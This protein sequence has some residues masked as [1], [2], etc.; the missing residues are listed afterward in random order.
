[1]FDSFM[2]RHIERFRWR[3]KAPN[4][5]NIETDAGPMK[6]VHDDQLADGRP[7]PWIDKVVSCHKRDRKGFHH[8]ILRLNVQAY[9]LENVAE[10]TPSG[11]RIHVQFGAGGPRQGSLIWVNLNEIR[12]WR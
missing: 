11:A 10:S 2:W 6:A 4:D 7:V 3:E 12:A 9:R 1:M 5:F 8:E